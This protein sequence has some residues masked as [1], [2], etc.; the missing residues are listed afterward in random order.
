MA[1]RERE[2][3]R[4]RKRE[5]E[6]IELARLFGALDRFWPSCELAGTNEAG[7]LHMVFLVVVLW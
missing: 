4:E 6:N 1:V 2:R 3:E 7:F 5:R